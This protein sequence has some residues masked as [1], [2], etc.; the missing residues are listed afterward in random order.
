[1]NKRFGSVILFA[2]VVAA[3]ASTLLYRLLASRM[4]AGA[5]SG[6][7]VVLVAA[8]NLETGELLRDS[9]FRVSDWSG[10]I[11]SGALLK[12]E[13]A[14]GRGVVANVYEGEPIVESRLAP[15]GAGAGLAA[16]IPVG[17]RA[18]A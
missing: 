7:K 15:R 12:K 8:R 14:I 5:Q 3:L 10:S 2:L 18:V 13:D 9:D 16:T 11:P 17:M 6:G 1:M 4:P